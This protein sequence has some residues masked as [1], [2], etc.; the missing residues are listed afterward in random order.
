M[1]LSEEIDAL[2]VDFAEALVVIRT[3]ENMGYGRSMNLGMMMSP[4]AELWLCANADVEFPPSSIQSVLPTI[5]R[6]TRSGA[7]LF[8]LGIHFSAVILTQYL[9]RKVGYFD[10]N[11]WPAY[12]EDCDLMLRVRMAAVGLEFDVE[13]ISDVDWEVPGH[14]R[15]LQPKPSLLHV[16]Q[17]GSTGSIAS[18]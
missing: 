2:S 5:D 10:A 11:L 7:M 13:S 18:R 3:R 17:Q 4:W 14:Y 8:M 6:E 15:Y 16:G 1:D 12:V 9:V